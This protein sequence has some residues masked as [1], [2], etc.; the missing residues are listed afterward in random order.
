MKRKRE[1]DFIA[2]QKMLG[3]SNQSTSFEFILVVT[4]FVVACGMVGWFMLAR[5]GYNDK[6]AELDAA[7][8]TLEDLNNDLTRQQKKFNEYQ[9]ETDAAGHPVWLSYKFDKDGNIV[10]VY[11]YKSINAVAQEIAEQVIKAQGAADEVKGI[12]DLTS[13]IFNLSYYPAKELGCQLKSFKYS[14]NSAVSLSL[15]STSEDQKL[16]FLRFME[17]KSGSIQGYDPTQHISGAKISNESAPS[18]DSDG[19]TTYTFTIT[20]TIISDVLPSV[21]G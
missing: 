10:Y 16:K 3:K 20:F 15:S 21:N 13:T 6:V 4:V 17:G 14:G 5:K 18:Y 1:I 2:A 8:S 9:I 19:V 12:I 7:K 11:K